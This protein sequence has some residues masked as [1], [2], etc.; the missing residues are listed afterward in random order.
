MDAPH[1]K[2]DMLKNLVKDLKTGK[3]GMGKGIRAKF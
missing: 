2:R 3:F 1:L